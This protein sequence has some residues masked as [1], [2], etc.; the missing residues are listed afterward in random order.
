MERVCNLSTTSAIRSLMEFFCFD[1][2]SYNPY[3]GA[4]PSAPSPEFPSYCE[5][6]KILGL[7]YVQSPANLPEHRPYVVFV[8]AAEA[9]GFNV[10]AWEQKASVVNR[11]WL[12]L[13][14]QKGPAGLSSDV[15]GVKWIA[16]DLS[17]V[18]AKLQRNPKLKVEFLNS[19]D[20]SEGPRINI[21]CSEWPERVLARYVLDIAKIGSD[22]YVRLKVEDRDVVNEYNQYASD[23]G[24]QRI[25]GV[26]TAEAMKKLLSEV[27]KVVGKTVTCT[28]L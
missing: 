13:V 18:V 25:E 3:G 22:D 21:L 19:C 7:T 5:L 15:K 8:H 11:Q 2:L 20:L 17:A 26:P 6:Q 28:T 23:Y 9:A 14:S 4:Q 24:L 16:Q 12:I 27:G 10:I 1:H